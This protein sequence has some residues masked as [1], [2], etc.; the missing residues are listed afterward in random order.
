MNLALAA[1]SL[2]S[3]SKSLIF[4]SLVLSIAPGLASAGENT[5]APG[6]VGKDWTCAH[7]EPVEAGV[8][9]LSHHNCSCGGAGTTF[10]G[11]FVVGSVTIGIGD[12]PPKKDA[13]G[14]LV[15][16]SYIITSAYDKRV[17]GGNSIVVP[18]K[19]INNVIVHSSCDNSGCGRALGFL[20]GIGDATCTETQEPSDGGH[21]NYKNTGRLCD[22]PLTPDQGGSVSSPTSR[23]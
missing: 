14:L 23:D 17:D 10:K 18:D 20:W 3:H 15:C 1:R 16:Q 19:F 5:S 7:T 22:N 2:V 11:E 12:G 4:A 8:V 6:P 9:M 13:D 21:W